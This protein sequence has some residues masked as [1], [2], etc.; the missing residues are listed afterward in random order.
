MKLLILGGV[1]FVGKELLRQAIEQKHD[2]T[3]ISLDEPKSLESVTWI[4]VNRNDEDA[5][6]TAL[7]DKEFDCVIDNIA[8]NGHHVLKLLRALNGRTKRY[9][10][11]STID[12]Y[13]HN[14]LKLADEVEDKNLTMEELTEDSPHYKKYSVGKRAAERVL[15]N[16][17]SAIEKVII[18]PAV[19]MGMDDNID[20]HNVPRSLIWPSKI[21]DNEPVLIFENDMSPFVVVDVRDVANAHL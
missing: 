14:K 20:Q 9:V 21:I 1:R 13:Q 8:Y 5:L 11:T 2:I 15:R 6:T 16:D 12:T 19:V 18:R 3:L 4:N 10:L 7:K 17:N